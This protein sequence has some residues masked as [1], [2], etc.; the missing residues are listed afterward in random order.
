MTEIAFRD[1]AAF[2]RWLA[3]LAAAGTR[4]PDD[5]ANFLD[6]S[7]LTSVVADEHSTTG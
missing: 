2:E 7:Y 4:V 5:E 1:R 3:A 6:R